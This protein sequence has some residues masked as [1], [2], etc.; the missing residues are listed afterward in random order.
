MLLECVIVSNT[1]KV[2]SHTGLHG[3]HVDRPLPGRLGRRRRQE[4]RRSE[5]VT[6]LRRPGVHDCLRIRP[7]LLLGLLHH[8]LH[9]HL[10]ADWSS[11]L[12]LL[13]LALGLAK[14]CHHWVSWKTDGPWLRI[15][16]DLVHLLDSSLE[17]GQLILQAQQV[18]QAA[19][20]LLLLLRVVER[21]LLLLLAQTLM[22]TVVSDLDNVWLGSSETRLVGEG[23]SCVQGRG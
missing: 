12:L 22:V 8:L 17:A 14:C 3:A 11:H 2:P 16:L 10:L 5:R 19:R 7:R 15:W 13:L 6:L 21:L 20:R 23:G 4:R 9:W 18:V 1:S